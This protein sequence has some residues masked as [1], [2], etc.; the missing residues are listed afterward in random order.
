VLGWV[1]G[2]ALW[3][4]VA[5]AGAGAGP[6]ALS[7]GA[8]QPTGYVNLTLAGPAG[9]RVVL[10]EREPGVSRRIAT[11]TLGATGRRIL[12]HA[13][14]WSCAPR[15][16]TILAHASGPGAAPASLTVHTP[17][18]THRLAVA[19]P[20]SATASR[21]DL[22]P[23]VDRWGTGALA[24]TVCE[25][26]PGGVS[27]CR[28]QTLAPGRSRGTVRLNLPRPGGYLI[29][30]T[31]H[32]GV[33][34]RRIVWVHHRD[35]RLTLLAAGDSEMQ[36]LDTDLAAD[37]APYRVRVSEDARPSTGLTVPGPLNWQAE[38]RRQVR[39]LHPD[40]TVVSMGAN[41]G[42]AIT[43]PTG[44]PV[45]CCGAAWTAGYGQLVFTMANTL[46]AGDLGRV[47]WLKLAT[48][49]P[50]NFQ[51]I[52]NRVN[53]GIVAAA[54]RLRG[55]MALIDANAFFT[56]G[57][58]YRNQMSYDGRRFTIHEPDGIH[59]DATADEIAARLIVQRLLA[60]RIIRPL[61]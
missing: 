55:R 29:T 32:A 31:G 30:I 42:Y 9:A 45:N 6:A 23:V 39:A 1:L 46:L 10:S 7:L 19:L 57:N 4:G 3:W 28:R 20:A 12:R 21:H 53:A 24:V 49:R 58:V 8:T 15:V 27:T 59:L 54:N 35:G 48:P 26:P 5:P 60:D 36:E 61:P 37:L 52:F 56:P 44:G 50:A 13:L 16:R 33:P 18:C 25:V 51:R 41:E 14:T 11:V 47:Y 34:H 17:A 40:V 38:A 43:G 22:I 2:A